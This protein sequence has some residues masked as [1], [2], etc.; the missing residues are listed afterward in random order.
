MSL[1]LFYVL[2]Y[3]SANNYGPHQAIGWNRKK[4]GDAGTPV[5]GRNCVMLSDLIVILTSKPGKL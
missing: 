5:Y 1:T 3:L 2:I 4:H